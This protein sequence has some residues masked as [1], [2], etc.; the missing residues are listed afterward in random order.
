MIPVGG[1]KTINA[2]QAVE[3]I[4]Q[5]EPRIVIPMHYQIKDLK[6]KTPLDGLETFIKEFGVTPKETVSKFKISKKDLPQDDVQL[7]VLEP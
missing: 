4:S 6:T 2:K 7:V 5:I 1:G 3:L